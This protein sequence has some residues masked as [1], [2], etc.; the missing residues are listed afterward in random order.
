FGVCRMTTGSL[1]MVA[2]LLALH[3]VFL[4][5]F[6]LRLF[7]LVR[8]GHRLG[9]DTAPATVESYAN[10]HANALL[11]VH[12]MGFAVFYWGLLSA[13]S[14]NRLPVGFIRPALSIAV[15]VLAIG[16]LSWAFLVFRSWR[17]LAEL[18]RGH[19]L[20]TEGPFGFVRHPIYLACDLLAIGTAI[21][22]TTPAVL[23][24]TALVVGRGDPPAPAEDP[25]LVP[26]L[27]G[28]QRGYNQRAR[29]RP[30]SS[31]LVW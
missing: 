22:V 27:G 6:L 28:R 23:D 17:L 29:Q 14:A 2:I 11:I 24:R 9:L 1:R 21:W 31:V 30:S 25:V 10:P 3:A 4:S 8:P 12:G 16:L 13:L 7:G 15:V 20:C 19:E 26:A 18:D 5:A